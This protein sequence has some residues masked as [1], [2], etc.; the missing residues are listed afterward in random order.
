MAE[1]W[2]AV[3]DNTWEF[4]L[5][6]GVTFHNGYE[7]TAEDVKFSLDRVRDP[8]TNAPHRSLYQTISEVV[9]VDDST[10]QVKT[11]E[12][13]PVTAVKLSGYGGRIM[14]QQYFDEVGKEVYSQ[15]PVGTG[16]FRITEWVK[17]S[18]V[19][20]EAF[21][22]YWRG[23][24][25]L[26][27]VTVRTIPDQNTRMAE[28]LA[29]GIDIA[30]RINPSQVAEINDSGSAEVMET[31]GLTVVS[32]RINTNMAPVDNVNVRKALVH[33]IDMDT[34][35]ETILEGF[36]RRI[37]IQMTPLHVG[38]NSSLEPY[39]YDPELAQSLLDEAGVGPIELQLDIP[40]GDLASKDMAEVIVAQWAEI[41]VTAN[42]TVSELATFTDRQYSG[43]LGHLW[44]TGWG[45]W[46]ADA[47]N[48]YWS[49]YATPGQENYRQ[50]VVFYSNSELDGILEEARYEM[51]PAA[52]Q[53]LYNQAG[54]IIYD[55]VPQLPLFQRMELWGVSNRVQ[56]FV[57]P[58]DHR[59]WLYDVTVSE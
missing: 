45:G 16:P 9:I 46:T 47:D 18:H 38:F 35:I 23:K 49:L 25:S 17:D 56:G 44:E 53:E 27:T 3:D 30:K 37:P 41:G 22:D 40:S 12:P 55:E 32:Y 4:T 28:L 21:D 14:S 5:R 42:L 43:E 57:P 26:Q 8:E 20:L 13:D 48:T 7:F 59:F 29:G 52:R 36:G 2:E 50:G 31:G 6:S 54:E 58:V 11:S 10:I 24:P 19:T 15:E 1:T 51:D 39:P 33:A 34:I